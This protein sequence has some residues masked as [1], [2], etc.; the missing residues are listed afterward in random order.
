MPGSHHKSAPKKQAIKK[1][2]GGLLL[3]KGK[4]F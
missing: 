4:E 1:E 2:P 3:L